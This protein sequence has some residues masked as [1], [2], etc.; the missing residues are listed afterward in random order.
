MLEGRERPAL[1]FDSE[2]GAP[3]WLFNGAIAGNGSRNWYAMAQGIMN[4]NSSAAAR[5][6]A[7]DGSTCINSEDCSLNGNCTNGACVCRT[8]WQ[9]VDCAQ[10]QILPS[11]TSSGGAIYGVSPRTGSWG[12]N[13]VQWADGKFHLFVAEFAGND[14]GMVSWKTNSMITHAIS[15]TGI[16]GTY[17]RSDTALDAWAHNP[18]VVVYKNE[19]FLFHIGPGDGSSVKVNCSHSSQAFAAPGNYQTSPVG[20]AQTTFIHAAPGPH[21][22]WMAAGSVECDNPAPLVLRNGTVLLMCSRSPTTSKHSGTPPHWRLHRADSPRGPWTTVAE[23]YP[24]SNRTGPQTEDPFIWEDVDGNLHAIGHTF[25]PGGP[26]AT[27]PSHV[28]SMHGYSRDGVAW[29]WSKGQPYDAT[30]QFPNG[31]NVLHATAE[32]PKLFIDSHGVPTHLVNGMQSALWPCDG[33]I[34]CKKDS[35]HPVPGCKGE[36]HH[37]C[38]KCKM[39]SAMDYTYTIIRNLQT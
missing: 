38:N 17:A 20:N 37:V 29:K 35:G 5:I 14:C 10:L 13:I 39:L 18:E 36:T 26:S 22:P 9:G 1:L 7:L 33:C 19:L 34:G 2:T 8:P 12:G 15:E 27:G 4:T 21:G 25:P 23:V 30:V 32:R 28:V 6:T 11:S 24:T 3:T 16:D 31:T